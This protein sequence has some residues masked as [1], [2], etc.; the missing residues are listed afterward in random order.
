VHVA[1]AELR[2]ASKV[3]GWYF[4]VMAGVLASSALVSVP[5]A[6]A[7]KWWGFVVLVGPFAVMTWNLLSTYYVV[8]TDAL[9]VR[10]MLSRRMVPLASVTKLRSSRDFRSA[11]AL[12]L[13]RIEV[14]YG[15]QS[16]LISPKETAEF[17]EAIR[18]RQPSV[19]IEDLPGEA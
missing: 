10:C 5:A 8:S 18:R 6:L 13:D 15:G 7:G 1:G 9:I 14:M 12:S 4:L 3:D 16:V 19:S 2:F 17:V 11:P